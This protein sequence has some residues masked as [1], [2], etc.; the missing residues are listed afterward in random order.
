MNKYSK[1][2]NLYF[3]HKK[4]FGGTN[5][6]NLLARVNDRSIFHLLTTL[7]YG[8]SMDSV[9]HIYW[10][11][12]FCPFTLSHDKLIITA[13][14]TLIKS[15]NLIS[16]INVY[17]I[18]NFIS[19]CSSVKWSDTLALVKLAVKELEKSYNSIQTGISVNFYASDFSQTVNSTIYLYENFSSKP[20]IYLE[21]ELF[22]KLNIINPSQLYYLVQPNDIVKIFSGIDQTNTIHLISKYNFITWNKTIPYFDLEI[23]KKHTDQQILKTLP[24]TE[25]LLEMMFTQNVTNFKSKQTEYENK[26]LSLVA[27]DNKRLDFFYDGE[28]KLNGEL[29]YK[30]M[31]WSIK[32]IRSV[33][34][35]K[36]ILCIFTEDLELVSSMVKNG[37]QFI[38]QNLFTS[39]INYIAAKGLYY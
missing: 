21:L 29:D 12:D 39:L 4:M 33:K 7:D 26:D 36:I 5:T 37:I 30:T 32:D 2:K 17:L 13:I 1:Y 20:D 8:M 22:C 25:L 24:V 15:N 6:N 9:A 3:Q 14:N 18:P 23:A 31:E 34:M 35:K 19:K 10:S 27:Y 28:I 16:N 11:E 38:N